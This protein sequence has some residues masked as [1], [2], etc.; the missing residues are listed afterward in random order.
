MK[1]FILAFTA[2]VSLPIQA[3]SSPIAAGLEDLDGKATTME[4]PA[5]KVLVVFWAT[6]CP[7]CKSE[8]SKELPELARMPN[9]E[10]VTV[11][12]DTDRERAKDYVSR[13]KI[14]FKVFRDPSKVYLPQHCVSSVDIL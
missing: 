4:S 13:E 2:L 9:V 12:T 11:N 14:P 8:F 6:W 1:L 7:S 5:S 10:V 3:W